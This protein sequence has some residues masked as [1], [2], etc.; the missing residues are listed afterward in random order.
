MGIAAGLPESPLLPP[1]FCRAGGDGAAIALRVYRQQA[2][3]IETP[4]LPDHIV[5]LHLDGA[6][7]VELCRDGRSIRM[8]LPRG[9]L[10]ILPARQTTG[11]RLEGMAAFLHLQ[12]APAI[13]QRTAEDD[14]LRGGSVAPL[15]RFGARDPAIERIGL[16][17]LR[18]A[19]SP[20]LAARVYVQALEQE[21]L[22]HLLRAHAGLRASPDRAA[23]ALADGVFRRV[24]DHIEANLD[25]ELGLAE[26]AAVAAMSLSGFARA[27][28]AAAGLPPHRYLVQ[29]RIERAKALLRA[30]DQ[31]VIE[32]ALA[33]GFANPQHFATVFR[34]M[35][36]V[37]PRAFRRER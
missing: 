5:A 35:L 7:P 10:T 13:L 25:Q 18:E 30:T 2:S 27:F 16:A 23:P 3:A 28:R 37:T 14:G 15:P 9:A 1:V 26:L 32:V 19:R 22:V 20:G 8:R 6:D 11:W 33:C 29:R 31:P 21:L 34:R 24:V 17:L 12:I 36:G 4:P